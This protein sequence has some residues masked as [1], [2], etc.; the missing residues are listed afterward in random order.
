MLGQVGGEVG[1]FL[2]ADK[3]GRQSAGWNGQPVSSGATMRVLRTDLEI[4]NA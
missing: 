2:V 3:H 1:E 4:S